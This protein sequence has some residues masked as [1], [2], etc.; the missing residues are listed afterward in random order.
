M[1]PCQTMMESEDLDL[2]NHPLAEKLRDAKWLV[3]L[4]G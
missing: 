1:Y 3:S 4:P 2:L